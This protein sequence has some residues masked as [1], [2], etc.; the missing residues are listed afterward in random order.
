MTIEMTVE[1]DEASNA[2]DPFFHA[3]AVLLAASTYRDRLT[4]SLGYYAP[5]MSPAVFER[6]LDLLCA[7]LETAAAR[8][9]SAR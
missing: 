6:L 7:E 1:V 3:P 9:Q 2:N 8:Q 5:E 4:L